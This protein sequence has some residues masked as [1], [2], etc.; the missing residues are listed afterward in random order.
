M[1]FIIVDEGEEE[2]KKKLTKTV[3]A[4]ERKA[5]DT[6]ETEELLFLRSRTTHL[7]ELDKR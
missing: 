3:K 1:N 7:E 2:K 4:Y 6:F 5:G